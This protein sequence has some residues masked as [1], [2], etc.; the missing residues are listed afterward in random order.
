MRYVSALKNSSLHRKTMRTIAIAVVTPPV[1][2]L[3][4]AIGMTGGLDLFLATAPPE[5][6]KL[7]IGLFMLSLVG[8]IVLR[9]SL[10]RQ[11]ELVIEADENGVR[12]VAPGKKTAIGWD[13]VSGLREVRIGRHPP[14]IAMKTAK[15]VFRF[16][17]YLVLDKPEAPQVRQ[18]RGRSYW[19]W[20]DGKTEQLDLEHSAGYSII[21]R[22]RPGLLSTL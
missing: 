11:M 10:Q 12:K 8:L 2:I 22:Y 18:K 5:V 19:V 15:G 17:P 9:W 14:F 6:P 7:L 20:S 1:I 16:D 4:L 13:E 3:I 21:A